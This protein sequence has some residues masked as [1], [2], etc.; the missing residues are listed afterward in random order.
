M[1]FNASRPCEKLAMSW[2]SYGSFD[3]SHSS[4]LLPVGVQTIRHMQ[5]IYLVTRNRRHL[6]NRVSVQRLRQVDG[7]EPLIDHRHAD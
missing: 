7:L 5:G 2:C 6:C 1:V 3:E 4:P